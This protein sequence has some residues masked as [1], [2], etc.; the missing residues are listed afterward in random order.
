MTPTIKTIPD[1]KLVG[2]RIQTAMA[3]NRTFELWS[4]FMPRRKEIKNIISGDLFSVQVHNPSTT[5][6][7]FT[8]HTPF[9]KWAAVEV[10]DFSIIPDGMEPYT[11]NGG[12]YAVFIHKGAAG[13]AP[14]TFQ[15]IFTGWLPASEYL[16]D[17]SRAQFEIMGEKYKNNHP[18][19]EEEVWIPIKKK[20]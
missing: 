6:E 15:Y 10:T 9:E 3:E 12:L 2:K 20:I 8:P 5:F 4:S 18:D 13:T 11:L 16:F 14:E 7:N 1:K 19:S 17:N